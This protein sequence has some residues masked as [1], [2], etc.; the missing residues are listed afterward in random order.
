MHLQ[1]LRK[2][3]QR[4]LQRH[5]QRHLQRHRRQRGPWQR[6]GRTRPHVQSLRLL[7]TNGLA[8]CDFGPFWEG[9]HLC[10]FM[11][12][13]GSA[14]CNILT[15]RSGQTLRSAVVLLGPWAAYGTVS[16]RILARRAHACVASVDIH[17]ISSRTCGLAARTCVQG[18]ASVMYGLYILNQASLVY[19]NALSV[20]RGIRG[21][22]VRRRAC[23]R[24]RAQAC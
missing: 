15:S 4:H 14:A 19:V 12:D 23:S 24:A 6:H 18:T 20:L 16:V 9:V 8:A 21:Y 2:W 10:T 5:V 1:G 3:L 7:R 11:Y 13:L 17:R 22:A